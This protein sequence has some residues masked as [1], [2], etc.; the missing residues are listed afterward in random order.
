MALITAETHF[1]NEFEGELLTSRGAVVPIGPGQGST[2]PYDLLFGA[3]ASCFYSTFLDIVEKMR[4][5]F[6][7]A[8]I[9]VSG[10][11]RV[12]IPTTLS[13]VLVELTIKKPSK[14]DAF[15]KAAALAGKYCSIYQTLSHVASMR[16]EVRFTD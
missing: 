14:R 2:S 10:E 7:A 13:W 4:V 15:E 8:D 16:T 3:L 12:E 5:D 11:K 6:E 1:K 9:A